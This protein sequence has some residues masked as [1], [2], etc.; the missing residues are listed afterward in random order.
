MNID[1]LSKALAVGKCYIKYK[2]VT[3]DKIHEG[4]YTLIGGYN[5]PSN[6]YS[7]RLVA[8]STET[9]MYEDIVKDS[10]LEWKSLGS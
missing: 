6:H 4:T 5:S 9:N 2:S 10:I 8:V 7:D 3:S 1:E